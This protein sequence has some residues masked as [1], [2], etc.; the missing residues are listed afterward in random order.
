MKEL[1][2]YG[3]HD[4]QFNNIILSENGLTLTFN[5][6]IYILDQSHKECN[7]TKQCELI[8][9]IMR[10]SS[11]RLYEHLEVNVYKKNKFYEVDFFDFIEIVEKNHFNI[12][13]VFYSSFSDSILIKGFSG[14]NKIEFLISEISNIEIHFI[15]S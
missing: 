10:F 3:L 15:E 8:I 11:T 12:D 13:D 14:K 1:E 4:T 7:L 5:S 9:K 2:K 6:G